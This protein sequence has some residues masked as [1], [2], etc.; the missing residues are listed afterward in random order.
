[1]ITNRLTSPAYQA[2]PITHV[3][4]G[5]DGDKDDNLP[6]KLELGSNRLE[7][8]SPGNFQ[9][10]LNWLNEYDV[11]PAPGELTPE[12][13]AKFLDIVSGS[14][15]PETRTILAGDILRFFERPDTTKFDDR[16]AGIGTISKGLPLISIGNGDDTFE[17][18]PTDPSLAGDADGTKETYQA[19]NIKPDPEATEEE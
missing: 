17:I 12:E 2:T 13:Q 4:M 6:A 3:Q 19:K 8:D 9:T 7:P 5:S 11:N 16:P 14:N 18:Q 10:L 1:M 15:P